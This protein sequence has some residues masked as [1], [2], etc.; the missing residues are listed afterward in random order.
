M[1]DNAIMIEG[2]TFAIDEVLPYY[3]PCFYPF[4]AVF[5]AVQIAQLKEAT[6]QAITTTKYFPNPF[7]LNLYF[8][9]ALIEAHNKLIAKDKL[10]AINLI[11][12][13]LLIDLQK[14]YKEA[15][16]D[17]S[18]YFSNKEMP[19]AGIEKMCEIGF[20]HMN[21]EGT[22]PTYKHLLSGLQQQYSSFDFEPYLALITKTDI[23]TSE[24]E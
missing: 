16:T 4:S 22:F 17:L 11:S 14:I 13:H 5:D 24:T 1:Q 3:E 9:A 15:H 7:T 10:F 12:C 8:F 6:R 23:T 19:Q 18:A 20:K 2:N 21:R